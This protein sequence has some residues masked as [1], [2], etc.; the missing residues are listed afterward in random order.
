MKLNFTNLFCISKSEFLSPCQTPLESQCIKSDT[1]TC[2]NALH[3]DQCR[4]TMFDKVIKD[5]D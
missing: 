3:N 1:T 2:K 4:D 5:H